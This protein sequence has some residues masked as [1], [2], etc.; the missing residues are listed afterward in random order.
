MKQ[1]LLTT[2]LLTLL[3]GALGCAVD[4]E[5]YVF[6]DDALE[7]VQG[8]GTGGTEAASECETFCQD[9]PDTCPFGTNLGYTSEAVCLSLCEGYS[10]EELE[11]RIVHL[12]FA[13]DDPD[14]HCPH[15]LEDGGGTCP[16]ARPDQCETFCLDSAITCPFGQ[17]NGYLDAEECSSLCAGYSPEE[18]E[19]RLVHLV[20][21][22]DD[23]ATHCKHTLEDGGGVCPDSTQ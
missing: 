12:R 23:Q 21:A 6:D 11:C 16:D 2:T 14:V 4:F 8:E 3:L 13:G 9:S 20:F 5:D 7:Q 10:D 18:L 15:T 1:V 22:E 19:C 17:E